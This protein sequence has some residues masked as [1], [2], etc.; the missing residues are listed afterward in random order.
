MVGLKE[1]EDVKSVRFGEK[2][3]CV[4]NTEGFLF[5]LWTP[6]DSYIYPS[7]CCEQGCLFEFPILAVIFKTEPP[8]H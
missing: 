5:K 3:I 4:Q 2:G 7:S 8:L 6:F 1:E